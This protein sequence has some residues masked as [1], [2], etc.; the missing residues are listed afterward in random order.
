M[1]AHISVGLDG[2]VV[3]ETRLGQIDGPRGELSFCGYSIHD[4]AESA[5]WE[6]VLYLLWH[7]ALP[8]AEQLAGLRAELEAAR[9]LT[10]DELA[11][12]RGLP[13][14]GHAMDVLR[15]A[16]SLLAGLHRPA[17]MRADSV[18]EEG[19]RLTGKLPL[20]VAAWARLRAGR[21]PVEVPGGLSHAAAM[22]Y[23]LHGA[24][25]TP[26]QEA[27]LN[28]YMVLL[29]EHGLNV[30]TFVA[31]I[32]ASAQNDLYAAI[33]AA[34]A[35]LKG[36]AHGGANE[37]AMR[38][39]LA[40]GAPEQVPAYVEGLVARGERLMGV[41]HRIYRTEDPRVRHLRAHSAHLATQPGADGSAHTVAEAV[42]SYVGQHPYF[43]SR[44]LFPNVEFYSAPLL[45]QLGL[46]L[47]CFTLAFAIARMPGWVAHIREQLAVARLVRPEAAYVGAPARSFV[48]LGRRN[49]GMRA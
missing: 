18:L 11:L 46:P 15:A 40:I 44:H 42:A 35:A 19:L 23:A 24:A 36:A 5:R 39:F 25:P 49:D 4:L 20:L 16:V 29:A 26:A 9:R 43:T 48:P 31:R 7:D 30:S 1:T 37:H 38:A 2:T 17:R 33:D 22:L 14:H 45:F 32:V 41:G 13:R 3:A 8:S 21:E 47:D 27:A 10:A 6:E 34:L 28:S 12:L